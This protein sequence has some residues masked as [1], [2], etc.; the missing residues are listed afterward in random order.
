MG[1]KIPAEV[2]KIPAYKK[3]ALLAAV[4]I[5]LL[6][7]VSMTA[8]FLLPR[9]HGSSQRHTALIYQNG[10]LLYEIDLNHI[11]E[12]YQITIAA[13][14]GGFNLVEVRPGSIGIIDASCPD[15]L[16]VHMGFQSSSLLPV[17]C[18]PNNLVIRIE[19]SDA[20]DSAPP[21][22]GVTY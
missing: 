16:C 3:N 22:D 5:L 9:I 11:S 4:F 8:L 6:L 19:P 20:T 18:L 10:I 2:K 1:K 17:I 14:N 13:D 7:A 21:M 12:S 15:R